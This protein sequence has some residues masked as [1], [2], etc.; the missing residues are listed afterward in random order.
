M[1][2][3]TYHGVPRSKIPW[4]PTI[5]YER[6]VGCLKCADYCHMGVYEVEEKNGKKR[7]VVKNPNRCVVMCTGCQDICPAKAIT[8][9]SLK[10]TRELIQKLRKNKT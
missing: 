1:A 2:E 10:E 7:S 8:H 4:G 6:C 9:P 5:D 3:E